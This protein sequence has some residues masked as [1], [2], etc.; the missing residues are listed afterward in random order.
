MNSKNDYCSNRGAGAAAD[1][2]VKR[3]NGRHTPKEDNERGRGSRPTTTQNPKKRT[4]PPARII[5]A[6]SMTYYWDHTLRGKLGAGT[7]MLAEARGFRYEGIS[8]PNTKRLILLADST[9]LAQELFIEVENKERKEIDYETIREFLTE[10]WPA[11][12]GRNNP[13]DLS[14]KFKYSNK[15]VLD[16]F[17]TRLCGLENTCKRFL[18][19]VHPRPQTPDNDTPF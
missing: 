18:K 4:F 2:F 14:D 15:R 16:E 5:P 7:I 1:R 12:Y 8:E 17:K 11:T 19:K 9:F 3:Y 10:Y 13:R 6:N